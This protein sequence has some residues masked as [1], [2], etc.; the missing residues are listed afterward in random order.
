MANCS[1]FQRSDKTNAN[2]DG[3]DLTPGK[4][5][6]AISVECYRC[7]NRGHYAANCP[8]GDK[9]VSFQVS[10]GVSLTQRDV[11][12][13]PTWISLDTCSTISCCNRIKLFLSIQECDQYVKVYTNS[14]SKTS[15]CTTILPLLLTSC[16][17]PKYQKFL[18]FV[19]KSTP[20]STTVSLSRTIKMYLN[21]FHVPM[22]FTT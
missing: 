3:E 13:T 15:E 21:F 18:A 14:G 7:H 16:P 10:N 6:T 11:Y 5:G 17:S 1:S 4:D 9:G 12:K 2:S 22:D 8:Q 19:S 20:P